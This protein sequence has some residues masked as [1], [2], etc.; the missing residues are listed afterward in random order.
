ML[1]NWP[2]LKIQYELR[3]AGYS[4]ADVARKCGVSGSW[5]HQVIFDGRVSDHV[6]RCIAEFIGADVKGIWPE[7]Y[8]HDSLVA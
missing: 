6:R 2:G 8:L 3:K 4:Q 7:Y 1:K 5:V